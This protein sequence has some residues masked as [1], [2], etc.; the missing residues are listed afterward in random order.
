AHRDDATT[1]AIGD[2]ELVRRRKRSA[3][4]RRLT[5]AERERRVAAVANVGRARRT[6]AEIVDAQG[7]ALTRRDTLKANDDRLL[8]ARLEGEDARVEQ[9]V[10]HPLDEGRIAP[11]ADDRFVDVSRLAGVHRLA[12]HELPIDRQREILKGRVRRQR[13]QIVRFADGRAA[14][15]EALF[16]LVA[17]YVI[18]E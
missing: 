9:T 8:P 2:V 11:R 5:V 16:D 10:P 18:G 3:E 6:S 1:V 12:S 7:V 14:I 17:Q 4:L 15:H 13:K